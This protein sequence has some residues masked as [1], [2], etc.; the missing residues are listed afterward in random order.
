MRR[1]SILFTLMSTWIMLLA[2][3]SPA[4]AQSKGPGRQIILLGAR[5]C[6]PCMAEWRN[7]PRLAAMLAPDRIV[8]AWVD[9]PIPV[10]VTLAPQVSAI[11]AAEAQALA[12][13]YGGQGFGLP[14]ATLID[15]RGEACPVWRRPLRP[16]DVGDFYRTCQERR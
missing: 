2:L 10:P 4:Q 5:W 14:M 16:E 8:L 15:G 7:L 9:R 1:S 3:S 12:V 11:P 6:A 13:K